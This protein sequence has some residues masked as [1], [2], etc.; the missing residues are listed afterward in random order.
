MGAVG[1][2]ESVGVEVVVVGLVAEVAAVGPQVSVK[3]SLAPQALLHLVPDEAT[4]R[5]ILRLEQTLYCWKL[6][7]LLPG[8]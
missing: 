4:M 7:V 1:Q 5:P 3:R 6:P 2:H 8:S